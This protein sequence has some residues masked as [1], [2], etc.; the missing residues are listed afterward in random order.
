MASGGEGGEALVVLELF[1][2]WAPLGAVR[3]RELVAAGFFEQARFFRVIKV[4]GSERL[5]MR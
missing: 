2:A 5:R 4:Q 1:P 3:F